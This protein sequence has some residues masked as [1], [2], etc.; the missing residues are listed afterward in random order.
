MST[1]LVSV[2][3][4]FRSSTHALGKAEQLF[5]ILNQYFRGHWHVYDGKAAIADVK[6]AIA[7]A[8]SKKETKGKRKAGQA[9]AGTVFGVAGMAVGGAAGSVA[10]PGV[11]TAVGAV[12]VGEMLSHAPLVGTHSYRKAKALYKLIKGTRGKHRMEAATV[13][14]HAAKGAGQAREPAGKALSVI[15]EDELHVILTEADAAAA[16]SRIADRMKSW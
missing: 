8:A 13:L 2:A 14:Y 7:Y 9:A 11:G 12:T 6:T 5:N 3:N 10:L 4:N 16:I 15:V 1:L